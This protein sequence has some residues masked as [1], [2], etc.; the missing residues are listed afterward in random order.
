MNWLKEGEKEVAIQY[1]SY[2]E[3]AFY[4]KVFSYVY[5]PLLR[6][7]MAFLSLNQQAFHMGIYFLHR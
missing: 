1:H 7:L 6:L 3:R 2:F 4:L 5:P